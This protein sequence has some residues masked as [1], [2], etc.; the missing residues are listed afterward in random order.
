MGAIFGLLNLFAPLLVRL[1]GSWLDAKDADPAMRESYLKFV[2][3]LAERNL[4][5]TKLKASY[6]DQLRRLK[7]EQGNGNDDAAS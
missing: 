7:E 2:S 3:A 4:I 1:L 5:P 6:A